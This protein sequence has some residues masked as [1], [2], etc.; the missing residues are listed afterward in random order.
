MGAF[1]GSIALWWASF[2]QAPNK[3]SF[4][5]CHLSCNEIPVIHP[6]ECPAPWGMWF[7]L[8]FSHLTAR[9]AE[10]P[11]VLSVALAC[12]CRLEHL[13]RHQAEELE[14][15]KAVC[16]DL[17]HFVIGSCG[18]LRDCRGTAPAPGSHLDH[19]SI[20]AHSLISCVTVGAFLNLSGP[21]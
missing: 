12:T 21:P 3:V 2:F 16:W 1:L 17:T 8:S 19:S 20:L 18:G 10:S 13:Y 9:C 14:G 6:V 5:L 4:I 7:A 11:R 15:L